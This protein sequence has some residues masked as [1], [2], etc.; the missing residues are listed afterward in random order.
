MRLG[1]DNDKVD[2]LQTMSRLN[3]Y[4]QNSVKKII[5]TIA[6]LEDKY[7]NLIQYCTMTVQMSVE[8]AP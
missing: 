6:K 1:D 3:K 2:S 7:T 5:K 8:R 4:A